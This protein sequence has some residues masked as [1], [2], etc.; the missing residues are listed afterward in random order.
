MEK[1]IIGNWKMNGSQ[2]LI[3][4]MVEALHKTIEQ[5]SPNA[6]VVVCP[7]FPYLGLLQKTIQ[8]TAVKAGAQNVY[9]ELSGAYTGEISVNMLNEWGSTYCIIG[10]SERR[11]YFGET[12]ELVQKKAVVLLENNITPV[13]CVGETLEQREK[14]EHESTVVGQLTKALDGISASDLARCIIAYEPVWAIGTGKTATD[15]QANDMHKVARTKLAELTDDNTAKNIPILYGGSVNAKNAAGLLSQ[16]DIDGS[17]VGGAS[18]KP[19]DFC[20]IV[21]SAP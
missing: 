15:E 14:G 9:Y 4:T 10:H 21:K 12:D 7:P 13:I 17:L 8:G 18:L 20:T 3:K 16:S 11:S 2:S 19:D 6:Q 5:D 1:F